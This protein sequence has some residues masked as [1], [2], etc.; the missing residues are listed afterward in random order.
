MNAS[1][2]SLRFSVMTLADALYF[3]GVGSPGQSGAVPRAK[4]KALPTCLSSSVRSCQSLAEC[5]RG[6]FVSWMN[7]ANPDMRLGGGSITGAHDKYP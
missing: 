5:R 2:S 3:C 6:F 1:N 4:T 7:N